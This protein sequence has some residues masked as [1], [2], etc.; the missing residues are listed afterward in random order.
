M[1]PVRAY[2]TVGDYRVCPVPWS[3]EV[4]CSLEKGKPA[5]LAYMEDHLHR[6]WWPRHRVGSVGGS[7]Y[8]VRNLV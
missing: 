6:L 7:R 1:N 5:L 2:I 3:G 4:R 8:L